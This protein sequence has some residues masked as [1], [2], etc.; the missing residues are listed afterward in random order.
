MIDGGQ[1]PEASRQFGDLNSGEQPG[2]SPAVADRIAAILYQGIAG[3]HY[4]E[5]EIVNPQ[6]G[7]GEIRIERKTLLPLDLGSFCERARRPAPLANLSRGV[8]LEQ[9][10]E[11][12][13]YTQLCEAALRTFIAESE[14][15]MNAM[16]AA[17]CHIECRVDQLQQNERRIRQEEITREIM[18]LGALFL[19]SQGQ[20]CEPISIVC[21]HGKDRE[22]KIAGHISSRVIL[23]F[24]RISCYASKPLRGCLSP[25][26]VVL[27]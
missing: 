24:R 20:T 9:L 15:R 5:V 19:H 16:A 13:V 26:R 10:S 27:R 2:A 1:I 12:Y 14:A 23:K 8:L 3:E 6:L 18:E 22:Q 25:D 7:A 21:I 4:I 17:H 11:E